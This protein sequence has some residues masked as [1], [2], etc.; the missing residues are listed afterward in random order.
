[1]LACSWGNWRR[2]NKQ[3]YAGD[4]LKRESG[5]GIK[6]SMALFC[7]YFREHRSHFS[8]IVT[9]SELVLPSF[10]CWLSLNYSSSINE[11]QVVGLKKKKKWCWDFESSSFWGRLKQN[12]HSCNIL[13]FDL[14]SLS[15]KWLTLLYFFSPV[16]LGLNSAPG[17]FGKSWANLFS[18]PNIAL[19]SDWWSMSNTKQ[20]SSFLTSNVSELLSG[21]VDV[22]QQ[23]ERGVSAGWMPPPTAKMSGNAAFSAQLKPETDG[24][25]EQCSTAS[26]ETIATERP[27]QQAWWANH[28]EGRSIFLSRSLR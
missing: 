26:A 9:S 13:L 14:L 22:C 20:Q 18:P 4:N 17:S 24:A 3:Y 10:P 1:M 2:A 27:Q 19:P 7:C 8:S 6:S 15:T 11:Q 5:K 23:R 16:S 21:A 28:V 25:S 12:V